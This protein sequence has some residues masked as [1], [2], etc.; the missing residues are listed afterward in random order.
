MVKTSVDC[1]YEDLAFN[2]QKYIR[3]FNV[4]VKSK[5]ADLEMINLASGEFN[6]LWALTDGAFDRK[7]ANMVG[8]LTKNFSK[9]SGFALDL[10]DT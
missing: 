2:V 7:I 6:T 5:S 3:E 1:P 8:N 4:S 10:T 9:K